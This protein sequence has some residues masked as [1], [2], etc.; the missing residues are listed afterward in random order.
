M[1]TQYFE[2]FGSEPESTNLFSFLKENPQTLENLWWKEIKSI[3]LSIDS[4]INF[5]FR[6]IIEMVKSR[7][8]IEFPHLNENATELEKNK[9]SQQWKRIIKEYES[10]LRDYIAKDKQENREGMKNT[11][12]RIFIS[13][14]Q[15]TM[16]SNG[17][18]E[19]FMPS[20]QFVQQFSWSEVVDYSDDDEQYSKKVDDRLHLEKFR[21]ENHEIKMISDI[22]NYVREHPTEKILVCINHHGI[23]DG[24]SGNWRTK[25]DWIR[26]ANISPNVKIRSIRCYF[27]TAFP[28]KEIYGQQS[29][30]SWFSNNTPADSASCEI[31]SEASNKNLWFHEMEIYTRLNYPISVSPLT[32]TM[33]YTDWNTWKIEMRNIWLARNDESNWDNIHQNDY[34]HS[35]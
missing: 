32:E 7:P 1:L 31:M 14:S 30:L 24:S 18:D 25:E 21:R 11:F 33:E 16:W 28:N 35:V 34:S 27:W 20:K 5:A 2:N 12:D 13:T 3:N 22:E 19:D 15:W 8:D 26:L 9:R 4:W 23:S 6:G 29:S 17:K 10:M